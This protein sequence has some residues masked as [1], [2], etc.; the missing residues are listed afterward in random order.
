MYC[1][2]YI[3]NFLDESVKLRK[4]LASR[5]RPSMCKAAAITTTYQCPFCP[6]WEQG[7]KFFFFFFLIFPYAFF[8]RWIFLFYLWILQ[9]FGRTPW[10]GDQYSAKASTY[11]GQHNTEKHRHTSMPRGGFEPA[12]PMSEW[13]KT[14][15]AL[16]RAA[17]ETA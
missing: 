8:R 14:V 2:G 1:E 13:P 6:V 5:Q 11:T 3:R 12:I 15:L 4:V 17:I 7:R 9:T 16:V 10:V